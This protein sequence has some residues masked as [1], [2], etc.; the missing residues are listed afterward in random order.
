MRERINPFFDLTKYGIV[1]ESKEA[2]KDVISALTIGDVVFVHADTLRRNGIALLGSNGL[3]SQITDETISIWNPQY[4][5]LIN[6]GLLEKDDLTFSKDEIMLVGV[7]PTEINIRNA[8]NSRY[9][10]DQR[11]SV[12][13]PSG[14]KD[15]RLKGIFNDFILAENVKSNKLTIASLGDIN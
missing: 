3:V 11:V 10:Y 7:I 14:T 1:W 2:V 6:S 5:L 13:T 9:K 15:L 12:N 4:Q 8:S